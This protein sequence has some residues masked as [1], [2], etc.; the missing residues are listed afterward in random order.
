MKLAQSIS[1]VNTGK[2]AR[3]AP[4]IRR[5]CSRVPSLPK[6]RTSFLKEITKTN[7]MSS[8]LAARMLCRERKKVPIGKG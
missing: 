4:S 5:A 3:G 2:T 6:M 7:A 1:T 8:E